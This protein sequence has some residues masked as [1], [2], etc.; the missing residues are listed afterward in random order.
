MLAVRDHV[1]RVPNLHPGQVRSGMLREFP[2]D[3][4]FV[5]RN[6]QK[7]IGY[8]GKGLGAARDDGCGR[9]VPAESVDHH[10]FQLRHL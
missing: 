3:A 6:D 1:R 2:P 10:F 9:I 8:L 4:F 5:S 7:K